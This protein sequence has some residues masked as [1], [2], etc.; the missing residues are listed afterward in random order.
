MGMIGMKKA[1][2]KV[3]GGSTPINVMFNPKEY[4]ISRGMRKSDKR[5]PGKDKHK[6][7]FIHGEND[8]L[9][10]S[11]FFDTY[12]TGITNSVL[13]EAMKKDVRNETNKIYKLMDT[14]EHLHKPPKV[15]FV[16]GEFKF[17]G[18]IVNI[19]QNFTMFTYK[20]VPVRATMDLTIEGEEVVDKTK[21]SPDRTKSHTVTQGE[22]L[23]QLAGEEYNDVSLWREIAAANCIENPRKMKE[24]SDLKIPS[25]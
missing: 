4:K 14:G 16:W 12:A 21:S 8:T 2:F 9:S 17:E 18:Y 25:L 15:T 3:E 23:W 1:M 19:S 11:L 10:L 22:L 6:K 13:P 24:G 5:V 7:Q 20:G